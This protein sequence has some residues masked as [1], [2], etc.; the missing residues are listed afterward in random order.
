VILSVRHVGAHV[1][2]AGRPYAQRRIRSAFARY[3]PAIQS[4]NV[5]LVDLNGPKGG[6]DKA[7]RIEVKLAGRPS[8]QVEGRASTIAEAVNATIVRTK[9][10]LMR[11]LEMR[12]EHRRELR[13]NS[14]RRRPLSS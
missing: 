7:C 9:R 6:T 5:S 14:A 10:L 11:S 1:A 8:I 2:A 4:I 13:R 3:S 12:G